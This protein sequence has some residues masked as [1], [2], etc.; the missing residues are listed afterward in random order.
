MNLSAASERWSSRTTFVLVLAMATVGLGNIWRFAWLMGEHGG[1]PFV[2]SY[3]CCLF[4]V[5]VPLLSAEIVIGTHGRGSPLSSMRWMIN[6][7]GRSRLWMVI[8]LLTCIAAF[9]LLVVCIVI[10]GWCLVYAFH[11]QLGSFAAMPAQDVAAFFVEQLE[12]PSALIGGQA[13]LA[14][15]VAVLGVLG[16]RRGLGVYAWV[17]LPM[18]VWLLGVLVRYALD[19]GD[20]EAA[21]RYLFARQPLDFDGGSFLA[22]LG[23]ALFTLSVG[24]AVGMSFGAYAPRKLPV[25]RSVIAVAL[26]DLVVAVA[27]GVALYPLL[28]AANLEPAREF[29][30]LFI[31]APYAYG[32]MPFGDVY[33]ALF[34][35]VALLLV[36]G[37]AAGLLEPVLGVMAQQFRIRRGVS[38]VFLGASAWAVSC[39]ATLGLVEQG[40][41]L[42]RINEWTGQLLIPLAMFLLAVFVAWRL[43][44]RLLRRELA[45]EPDA[46]FAVWYFLLRFVAVPV[47]G[48]AWLWLYLVPQTQ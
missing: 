38:A 43:P 1:A 25:L 12:A 31:A 33:G 45:R 46:L 36:L 30:L 35:T 19:F 26:F 21:G 37:S 18:V 47:V 44:R 15:A 11:Q 7:A 39:F 6:S 10:G 41:L 4:A 9:L 28:A 13:V 14:A 42:R 8:P 24:V 48:A 32:A 16:L 22:A 3:V 5:G 40:A 29:T 34:F 20:L 2:L 27:A 17:A 23:H